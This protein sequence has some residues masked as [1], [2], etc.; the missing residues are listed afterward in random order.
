MVLS[1]AD[2][3]LRYVCPSVGAVIA[4]CMFGAP[5]PAVLEVRRRRFLGDTNALPFAAMAANC[6]AWI[7]YGFLIRDWFVYAP[8][9]VGLM[10]G[11]FCE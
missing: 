6:L 9:Y 7:F 1:A 2:I 11:W 4:L 10:F 5:M 3:V 8:N